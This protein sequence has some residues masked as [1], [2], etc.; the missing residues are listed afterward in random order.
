MKGLKLVFILHVSE[1]A[2]LNVYICYTIGFRVY[3]SN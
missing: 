3:I 2:S 1:F